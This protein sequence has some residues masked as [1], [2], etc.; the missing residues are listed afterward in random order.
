MKEPFAD[1]NRRN[2]SG[3][4]NGSFMVRLALE[5]PC[6]YRPASAKTCPVA[7]RPCRSFQVMMSDRHTGHSNSVV[8]CHTAIFLVSDL[9]NFITRRDNVID[10]G[11]GM[12][13]Y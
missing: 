1:R 12:G 6:R 4:V 9:P 10:G 8:R 3:G 5:L 7:L 2:G 11:M 13:N